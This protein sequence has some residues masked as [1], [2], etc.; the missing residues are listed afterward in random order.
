M[1]LIQAGSHLETSPQVTRGVIRDSDK[2]LTTVFIYIFC[3]YE[4]SYF[5]LQRICWIT[6]LLFAVRRNR[7][8]SMPRYHWA[9]RS[10]VLRFAISTL[11]RWMCEQSETYVKKINHSKIFSDLYLSWIVP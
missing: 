11:A 10:S 5:I 8:D 3:E 1:S 4:K 2:L 9:Y 6:H 7:S